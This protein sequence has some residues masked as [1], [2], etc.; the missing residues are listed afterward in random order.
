VTPELALQTA[1]TDLLVEDAG[2]AA[3]IAGR[4][5]DE[6]P[7]PEKLGGPA[8]PWIYLGHV[9]L[10]RLEAGCGRA[11][12]ATIRLYAASTA[13]G[14]R[15]A[16][17]LAHAADTALEEAEPELPAGFTLGEPFRVIQ[18][19][20][21]ITPGPDPKTVFVDVATTIATA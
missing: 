4:V 19:G 1:I 2:V 20:D 7:V 15:Q 9:N 17:E 21:V 18:A 10:R 3:I 11:W 5:Y 13:F 16:W 6:V 12:T 8:L 14:R